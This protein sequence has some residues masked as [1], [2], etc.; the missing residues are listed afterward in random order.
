MIPDMSKNE[1]TTENKFVQPNY[2][3]TSAVAGTGE[4]DCGVRTRLLL[5]DGGIQ[6]RPSRQ[7]SLDE[8][9]SLGT[10]PPYGGDRGSGGVSEKGPI[11]GIF[12]S[13]QKE[14]TSPER[15]ISS[16]FYMFHIT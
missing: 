14:P 3:A 2:V 11:W 5:K 7:P 13:I 10:P 16:C 6:P 8:K 12:F 1:S 15:P 4:D 9:G